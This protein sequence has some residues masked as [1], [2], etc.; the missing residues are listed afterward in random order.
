MSTELAKN[1]ILSALEEDA[2][3]VKEHVDLALTSRAKV[4]IEDIKPEFGNALFSNEED[5]AEDFSSDDDE[6]DDINETEILESL[7]EMSKDELDMFLDS[8]DEEEAH[9]IF[10]LINDNK[11]YED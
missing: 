1:I 8:L 6:L 10:N 4:L 9:E 7:Q 2:L 11:S 5:I 3:G